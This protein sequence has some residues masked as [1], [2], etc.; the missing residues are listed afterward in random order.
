MRVRKTRHSPKNPT[1]RRFKCILT[2]FPCIGLWIL[3]IIAL[4]RFL[5]MTNQIRVNVLQERMSFLG[6]RGR[7]NDTASSGQS[8]SALSEAGQGGGGRN[9]PKGKT[10]TILRRLEAST[11]P[12]DIRETLADLRK[13]S[14]LRE[15]I[16]I[17]DFRILLAILHTF[18]EDDLVLQILKIFCLL[19]HP[20]NEKLEQCPPGME[21]SLKRSP[22]IK[23][24]ADAAPVLLDILKNNKAESQKCAASLLREIAEEDYSSIHKAF[25]SPSVCEMLTDLATCTS[26]EVQEECLQLLL[27]ITSVDTELQVIFGQE[28]VFERL[29][30]FMEKARHAEGTS[31]VS[32]VWTIVCN[33][34]RGNEAS[35]LSFVHAG[36]LRFVMPF[37]DSFTSLLR[38]EWKTTD[39]KRG[40]RSASSDE[41]R[42]NLLSCL[43][44]M[45]CILESGNDSYSTIRD[46]IVKVGAF[47]AIASVALCGNA[48][49]DLLRIAALRISAQL[50]LQCEKTVSN[51]VNLDVVTL[52]RSEKPSERV[53]IWPATR[54]LME[55]I[56]L[57]VTDAALLDA[58]LHVFASLFSVSENLIEKVVLLIFMGV[59]TNS[60]VK[61]GSVEETGQVFFDILFQSSASFSSKYYAA[62]L[63]RLLVSTSAGAKKFLSLSVSC[64]SK[65]AILVPIPGD[66]LQKKDQ[67][68]ISD[69]YITY[70]I[71]MLHRSLLS[72]TT[73]SAY[74]GVLFVLVPFKEGVRAFVWQRSRFDS[75]LRLAASE[76]EGSV[77]VRFWCGALAAL[78]CFHAEQ[79]DSESLNKEFESHLGGVLFF[80]NTL[81]DVKASTGQWE[82]PA[83][84]P[85]ACGHPVLYDRLFVDLLQ[86]SMKKYKESYG[87]EPK[88]N[89]TSS[90]DSSREKETQYGASVDARN[91]YSLIS[92]SQSEK[93]RLEVTVQSLQQA[94]DSQRIELEAKD[95]KIRELGLQTEELQGIIIQMQEQK[96]SPKAE[97]HGGE[98]ISGNED[99]LNK[100]LQELQE[101]INFLSE[102][103]I[104]KEAENTQLI[105]TIQSMDAQLRG[106]GGANFQE[107]EELRRQLERVFAERDI[108]LSFLGY[109]YQNSP[110]TESATL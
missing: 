92:G 42:R 97:S 3:N 29:L 88:N 108:I 4:I 79:E 63:L 8:L 89:S 11:T 21:R 32:D 74:I 102:Q 54:A 91:P 98:R 36:Y 10:Y 9:P 99:Y 83:V 109:V 78:V 17:N 107:H 31:V 104:Q 18:D 93:E 48:V 73:L 57:E 5:H 16:E 34:L 90:F 30:S 14:D 50:L 23:E 46:G 100:D 55:N 40:V 19:V 20:A 43:Q 101:T 77:H 105:L 24:L 49:D 96:T 106:S 71:S 22:F 94:I 80:R 81:F 53:I 84:S 86:G 41:L 87:N 110:D 39:E 45:S 69:L 56:A 70:A 27:F 1:K 52:R 95:L 33:V 25:L 62:H 76:S 51:F 64:E 37:F 59:S 15:A 7:K 82:A 12:R 61:Q 66:S 65:I 44:L 67:V 13:A 85:F 47:E 72:T 28:K 2:L 103:N 35:Q 26:K 58:T 75:L 60:K 6:F 68:M 38:K